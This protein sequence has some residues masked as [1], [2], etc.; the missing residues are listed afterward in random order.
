MNTEAERLFEAALKVPPEKRADF[1]SRE[2]ADQ[3]VRCEVEL[4]LA[5]DEGAE[6][7]L[8]HAVSSAAAS[9]MRS[10]SMP[11]GSG[12]GPYRIL[13][14]VGRGGMGVVYLAERSDGLFEQRVAIKVVQAGSD[15]SL[16]DQRLQQ[17]CRILATLDHPNIARLHDAGSTESGLPYFV[18]EYIQGKPIDRFCQ[19]RGLSLH[20]RLRLFLPVCEAVHFAHQKLI[21][22]RDL[23]PDN[24]LVTEEG[25]PKLLDFGIAKVLSESPID[26]QKTATR[27]L[28]PAYNSR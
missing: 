1:L 3:A 22:H 5:H 15:I 28:T 9:A 4:L 14:M 24:I 2:C 27:A 7:F 26:V 16:A 18:M 8:E 6:T 17:E 20:D 21:V 12:L 11:A 13:A 25:V 10:L 23:K 19:E